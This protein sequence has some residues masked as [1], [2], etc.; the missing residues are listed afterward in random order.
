M[1]RASQQVGNHRLC[2][3]LEGEGAPSLCGLAAP[4][5]EFQYTGLRSRRELGY[6]LDATQGLI[7]STEILIDFLEQM[8]TILHH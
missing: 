7:V 2:W 3:D 4:R 8:F 6:G 5:I 1:L